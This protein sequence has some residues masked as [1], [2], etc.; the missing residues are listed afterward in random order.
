[1][2][3]DLYL[4]EKEIAL[5]R[6]KAQDFIKSQKI[7]VNGKKIT[8]PKYRVQEDDKIRLNG[9]I[10]VS[11]SGEKLV[12]FL[13]KIPV[14]FEDRVV[15][16]VGASTGG[17]TEVALHRGTEKVYAVDVG[18]NQL[19]KVLK[20][21]ERVVSMEKTDI[22]DLQ[23]SDLK[24]VIE[25]VLV[26]VSFI[27]LKEVLPVISDLIETNTKVIALFKPQFEVG[28]KNIGG[29][30]IVRDKGIIDQTVAEI[31]RFARSWKL[32]FI[33]QRK[34]KLKGKKGNQEVFLLLEKR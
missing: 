7:S 10:Y 11:R 14:D 4:V 28:K 23:K 27:S 26:D 25:I 15:L 5:T 29:G 9:E 33:A 32:K 30:G 34:S 8:K 1:M 24:E 3:L 16:D 13:N 2:R 6:S 19:E 17:F 21:N 31:I 22:R 18:S 20:E 12:S